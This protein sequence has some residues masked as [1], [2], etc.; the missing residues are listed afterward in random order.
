MTNILSVAEILSRI[1]HIQSESATYRSLKGGLGNQTFFVQSDDRKFIL[2]LDAEHTRELG[3]NR[4]A[5]LA[6]LRRVA[7]QG[8]APEVVFAD[9]DAGILLYDYLPGRVWTPTDLE[10]TSNLESLANLIR[11]VHALPKSGIVFDS[12]SIT[13]R[14]SAALRQSAELYPVA[15]RCKEIVK[16]I[17][18]PSDPVCCHNDIVAAN[19]IATPK[20]KLL[21]W[22]YACDNDPLFDLASLIGYH[23]LAVPQARSLLTAYIGNNDAESWDRLQLQ[24]RLYNVIQWL[25]FAVLYKTKPDDALRTRLGQIAERIR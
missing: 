19:I 14:Y 7:S 9:P 3:L 15:R 20:L 10:S 4:V 24:L 13:E 16:D 5:E 18:L 25:W 22:E 21:D 8:L 6:I 23:D 17:P 12:V 11:A 1:P 2:R